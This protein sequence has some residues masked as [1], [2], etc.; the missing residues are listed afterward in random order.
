MPRLLACQHSNYDPIWIHLSR[1]GCDGHKISHQTSRGGQFPYRGH[2]AT[3]RLPHRS[4]ADRGSKQG[5]RPQDPAYLLLSSAR[6]SVIVRRFGFERLTFGPQNATPTT[7][8]T[9]T[10]P[11]ACAA[12]AGPS[13]FHMRL[14][15]HAFS[16]RPFCNKALGKHDGRNLPC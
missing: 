11:S 15:H 13:A 10:G 2:G 4:V 1:G 7:N 6:R 3:D 16:L 8:L 9:A 12:A 14:A 5:R